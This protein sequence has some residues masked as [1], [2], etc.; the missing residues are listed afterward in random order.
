MRTVR[1][2]LLL[3]Q[4]GALFLLLIGGVNL[5]NLLLIR[6]SGRAREFAVRQA[7][8]AARR[9]VVREV[10][11]ETVLLGAL[12][13]TLG[14]CAS[15]FGINLLSILGTEELPLGAQVAFD[16]R[17]AAVAW[18]GSLLVGVALAVPI[19]WF[20]LHQ[21]LALALQ[22]ESR[23]GTVSH[24]AQHLRQGFIVAQIALAFM[25]L[26]GAGLL[27][28]SL[29]RVLAVS[30]GFQPEHVLSGQL[31]LPV[32][33]YRNN[34]SRLA[35]NERLL[36]ELRAQP[37]VTFAA[38]STSAPFTS[39]A[40][41]HQSVI[42]V[43]GVVAQPGE[44]FRVHTCS[45]IAG[46]YWPALGIPLRASRLLDES[47]Q[48]REQRV[49]VVDE[50]FAQRYWP[51]GDAIGHRLTEHSSFKEAEAFTI[52]GVVGDVKTNDLA[53]TSALG[54]VYFPYPYN[55]A[56][57]SIDV[58]IRTRLA[59]AALASVLQ[60]TVQQL[61]P[62]LPVDDIRTMQARID[63]SLIQ[64]RSPALLAGIFASVALL[65]TAVGTYGVVAHA[66]TQRSREIGVRMALGALPQQVLAQF[67][68]IGAKLLL[69][70]LALGALGAW[71]VGRVM[72]NF[73]F[74]VGAIHA[75]VLATNL[76]YSISYHI[77]GLFQTIFY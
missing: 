22:T 26:A 39:R 31:V 54:A 25:L 17:V 58:F 37:G 11:V 75:G 42:T 2:T 74:G 30:P 6:A 52:V 10:L 15:A 45:W 40:T 3:L 23:G 47:D 8:G 41:I 73:L 16:G 57:D 65:L 48:Y 56:H 38:I 59:P 35:F 53:E 24:A 46:D 21:R 69:A 70:G 19:I 50:A 9:D 77:I 51:K 67:L 62:E 4:G 49:C 72:E 55:V 63:A 71:A 44:S 5:V 34:P 60:K 36:G 66:V 18:L 20:N 43:E 7:L 1:P 64:R 61:D 28:V 32:S 12:G 14:L 13:G 29:R 68:G 27:G 76:L 33:R